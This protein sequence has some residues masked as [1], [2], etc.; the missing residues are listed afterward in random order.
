MGF[1]KEIMPVI[2]ML[3]VFMPTGYYLAGKQVYDVV[4][5]TNTDC[6]G[7]F[8]QNNHEKFPVTALRDTKP[9]NVLQNDGSVSESRD[10]P[11]VFRDLGYVTINNFYE[12]PEYED[13]KEFSFQNLLYY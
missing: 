6:W 4:A 13:E 1:K 3:I 9:G 7:N 2:L 5:H 11:G 8:D 10:E 12:L